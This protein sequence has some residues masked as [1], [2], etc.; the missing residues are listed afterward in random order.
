MLYCV[1]C[2]LLYCVCCVGVSVLLSKLA[3]TIPSASLAETGSPE[4]DDKP[5]AVDLSSPGILHWQLQVC[6]FV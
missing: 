1:L 4:S 2:Y 5:V 3:R 6:L